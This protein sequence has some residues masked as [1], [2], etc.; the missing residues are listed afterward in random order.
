MNSI[1]LNRFI[2][3]LLTKR[4]EMLTD[5]GHNLFIY[6]K[7]YIVKMFYDDRCFYLVVIY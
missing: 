5:V 4:S 2:C 7:L 1:M 3:K 6:A